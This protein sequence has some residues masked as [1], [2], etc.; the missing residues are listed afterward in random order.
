MRETFHRNLFVHFK[1]RYFRRYGRVVDQFK[2][3]H[4]ASPASIVSP[5]QRGERALSLLGARVRGPAEKRGSA[6]PGREKTRREGDMWTESTRRGEREKLTSAELTKPT[7]SMTGTRMLRSTINRTRLCSSLLLRRAP[8]RS[9]ARDGQRGP[10]ES[11]LE[12]ASQARTPGL[13]LR[14]PEFH[15]L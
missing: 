4:R 14:E 10:Q 12:E 2:T 7:A 9:A 11:S 3:N 1:S 15:T 8:P 6:A 13:K 5:V